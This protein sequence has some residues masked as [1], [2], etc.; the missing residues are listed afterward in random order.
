MPRLVEGETVEEVVVE[1][2]HL[3]T[4]II[5]KTVLS[6]F[7]FQDMLVQL[8]GF[9]NSMLF[10]ILSKFHDCQSNIN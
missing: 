1:E 7:I 9:I 2:D 4:I 10:Q 3:D 6:F 5:F 8:S